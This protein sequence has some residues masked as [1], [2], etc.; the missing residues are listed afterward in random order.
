MS[1]FPGFIMT[2]AKATAPPGQGAEMMS[3]IIQRPYAFLEKELRSAFEG[4]GDVKIII[5][6]RYSERRGRV[7]PY[8][9]EHRRFD[10][11]RPKEELAE[12][13]T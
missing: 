8:E 6:R 12:V 5:D 7:Q 9:I 3:V 10:R 2:I 4:Q 1:V 13:L 11:R